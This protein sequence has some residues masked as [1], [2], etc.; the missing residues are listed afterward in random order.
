[1]IA[2]TIDHEGRQFVVL[3][4]CP[5]LTVLLVLREVRGAMARSLDVGAALERPSTG[6][7]ATAEVQPYHPAMASNR[8]R[9]SALLSEPSD[10]G[11]VGRTRD[12]QKDL[13]P[14]RK[15]IRRSA[16]SASTDSDADSDR[17]EPALHTQPTTDDIFDVSED[18]GVVVVPKAVRG[19]RI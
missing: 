18:A 5:H 19:L 6:I 13:G 17:N 4:K 3:T 9:I 2:W 8:L 14:S 11:D 10:I 12:G 16:S 1:M 7:R 15:R